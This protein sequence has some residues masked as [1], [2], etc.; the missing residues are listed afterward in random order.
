MN[1][2]NIA[3]LGATGVVGGEILKILEVGNGKD[4]LCELFNGAP[5]GAREVGHAEVALYARGF[6]VAPALQRMQDF[7][8]LVPRN[9]VFAHAASFYD[10]Q[11]YY[12][13]PLIF[14]RACLETSFRRSEFRFWPATPRLGLKISRIFFALRLASRLKIRILGSKAGFQTCSRG[15]AQAD[16]HTL[17]SV[18]HRA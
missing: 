3:I 5:L 6:G 11:T 16:T 10:I 12:T 17:A 9:D 7:F 4:A 15:E 8:L 14:T 13:P 1:K 18:L 2:P